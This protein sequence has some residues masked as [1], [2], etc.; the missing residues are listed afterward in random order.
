M[1]K[2]LLACLLTLSVWAAESNV[3][4]V[5]YNAPVDKVLDNMLAKFKQEMLV[6]VWQL[7]ILEEFKH[8]GLD[9]KFGENFNKAGLTAVKTLVACNG[10]FGNDI[11]NQDSDMMAYCPIRITLTEKDGVTTVLYV[12]PSSAPRDSK[13]YQSL[14]KLEKKVTKAIE[15]SMEME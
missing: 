9:K 4:K 10:K 8:K 5:S 15:E 14:V 3:Y 1:R 11:I 12:R 6:V 13:A 2:I 7:D